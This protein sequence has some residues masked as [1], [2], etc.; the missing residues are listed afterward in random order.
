[1][2]GLPRLILRQAA[3]DARLDFFLDVKAQLIVDVA[4]YARTPH[5][6]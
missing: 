2:R 1:M 6:I 3:P 5:E 4:L